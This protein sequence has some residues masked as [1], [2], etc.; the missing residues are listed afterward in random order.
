M[1]VN[2]ELKVLFVHVPKTAGTSIE[3]MLDMSHGEN[4]YTVGKN[5]S[6]IFSQ[7]DFS[8]FTDEERAE[9]EAKNLQHCTYRELKKLLPEKV[10]GPEYARFAVVR[11]PYTRIVSEY[12]YLKLRSSQGAPDL[13]GFA[14][15]FPTLSDF[16]L[17]ELF[18][19]R[20]ERI[21]KYDGHLEPQCEFLLDTT[22]ENILAI[23]KPIK[24]YYF[25]H[26]LQHCMRWVKVKSGIDVPEIQARKGRYDKE[27]YN[28]SPDALSAINEF[29]KKDFEIFKYPLIST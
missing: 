7:L 16:I 27:N 14:E 1:P 6:P 18:I 28:F 25:E 12:V 4:F 11:N 29:Y 26:T 10:F 24:I 13:V 9:V 22:Y 23:D 21:Y 15:K 17:S 2:H 3:K 8:N 19:P 5:K 20:L